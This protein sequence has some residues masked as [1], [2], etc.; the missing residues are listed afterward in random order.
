MR[1][2]SIDYAVMEPAS[3]AGRVAMLRA[4]VGWSDLG[5]WAALRDAL[6]ARAEQDGEPTGA[7]GSG[8]RRDVG[9]EGTLVLAGDRLVVTLGLRDTIVVD[10]PDALLVCAAD[11]SQE[12]RGI[13]EELA[14]AREE[15]L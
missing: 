2:T 5:S 8:P 12:V 6:V 13:A 15:D 3:V 11:R 14:R 10:T 1:A 4:D 7:V 9:S